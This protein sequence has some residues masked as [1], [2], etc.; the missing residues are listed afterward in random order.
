MSNKQ[1]EEN[2]K[3]HSPSELLEGEVLV[4]S[5]HGLPPEQDERRLAKLLDPGVDQADSVPKGTDKVKDSRGYLR[6]RG[7]LPGGVLVRHLV[8]AEES[9][10][11]GG[12]VTILP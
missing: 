10:A 4:E 2:I 8:V 6:L 1:I 9:L 12:L 7:L 5:K 3:A 11:D